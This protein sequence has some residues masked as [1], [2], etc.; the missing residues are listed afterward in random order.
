[1]RRHSTFD[2]RPPRPPQSMAVTVGVLVQLRRVVRSKEEAEECE[3][4]EE[5]RSRVRCAVEAE[6][7][8]SLRRARRWRTKPRGGAPEDDEK[9]YEKTRRSA[10][11]YGNEREGL[12]D[13]QWDG[14]ARSLCRPP[15]PLYLRLAHIPP[16]LVRAFGPAHFPPSCGRALGRG[17]AAG[18]GIAR[19]KLQRR[20]IRNASDLTPRHQIHSISLRFVRELV[21]TY[22]KCTLLHCNTSGRMGISCLSVGGKQGAE[23]K[24]RKEEQMRKTIGKKGSVT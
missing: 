6:P 7:S 18:R 11:A 1:M 9:E 15:A 2:I 3:K 5:A 19:S 23:D 14:R 20:L 13:G 12:A 10:P 16:V 17:R 24:Q 8:A 21:D 22:P 4:E